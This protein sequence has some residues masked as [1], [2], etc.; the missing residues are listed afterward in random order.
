MST[1]GYYS[2]V[3]ILP[4]ISKRQLD[5]TCTR[6]FPVS[7]TTRRPRPSRVC[8][9]DKKCETTQHSKYTCMWTAII[10]VVNLKHLPFL[11]KLWVKKVDQ[12][13][14]LLGKCCQWRQT[15]KRP[16]KW[17]IAWNLS[18][19]ASLTWLNLVHAVVFRHLLSRMKASLFSGQKAIEQG[20]RKPGLVKE[21][22]RLSSL[23]NTATSLGTLHPNWFAT[24]LDGHF[25]WGLDE[26]YIPP[27]R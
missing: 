25:R 9:N 12:A 8:Y 19:F 27:S 13:F 7:A 17:S 1:F 24:R 23:P 10:I 22:T 18:S 3:V 16:Q 11:P 2:I 6:S 14:C 21:V 5:K 4:I 15:Q 26:I 20:K